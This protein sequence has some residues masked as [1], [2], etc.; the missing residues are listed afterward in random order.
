MQK[1]AAE[2]MQI[3][4]TRKTLCEER[5]KLWLHDGWT[6]HEVWKVPVDALVLNVDNRR[7]A[8][9]R[10]WAQDQLGRNLDPENYP[11]DERCI[12]SLLLDKS[13]RVDNGMIIGSPSKD[14]EALKNDWDRRQQETPFWIRPDGTVRNGNRRLAMILRTQRESGDSGLKWVTAVI[15][16]PK[17]VD[18]AALLEM[19]QR[20]QL[21]ENFKVR[22]SDI[23]YLLALRE[24]AAIRDVD[25]FNPESIDQ[26][27]G[28]LQTTVEKS[29][30][31]VIR[32]LYAIKYMDL[33]L[34]DTGQAGQYHRIPRTLE[35]FRDIGRMMITV[36]EDYPDD[37]DRVLK[38][39]FAVVHAGR[40][41]EDIRQVR[42]MFQKDRSRFDGLAEEISDVEAQIQPDK[43]PTLAT[44]EETGPDEADDEKDDNM[45]DAGPTVTNYPPTIGRLIDVAIDGYQASRQRDIL[46]I[47]RE[48]GNRLQTLVAG[49]R[50]AD[51]IAD[52][53]EGMEIREALNEIV[54]WADEHRDLL[55]GRG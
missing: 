40:K 29:K 54:Q 49:R 50:L 44:P 30:P 25:W 41:Y 10:L 11:D 27:A 20:E 39:L 31:E 1:T 22:Y 13:H 33:F 32:D 21:T 48:V 55:S 16:D 19:E 38:V 52:G 34:E 37:F 5:A 6:F 4:E 2:R 9:E 8:V 23:D 53:G 7:F 12:E 51:A 18:E 17:E 14:Y 28:K 47:L 26:V 24:A 42:Q 3:I 15:L 45:D 36:E 46:K 35:I 43:R